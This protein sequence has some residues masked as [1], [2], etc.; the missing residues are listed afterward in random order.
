MAWDDIWAG[1][2]DFSD[3][4]FDDYTL[5]ATPSLAY[6]S[7]APFQGRTSPAQ[8][9][10]WQGQFGNVQSEYAGALGSSIRNQTEAPT[11]TQFLEDMPWTERYTSLSPALRPGSSFS[12]FSPQARRIYR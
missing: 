9:K 12:R 5:E 6:F 1:M 10:Y 3:R 7:S 8:R 2:G 4:S 11:F